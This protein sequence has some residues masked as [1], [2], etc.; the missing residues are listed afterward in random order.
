VHCFGV[1]AADLLGVLRVGF[2]GEI[3]FGFG[4]VFTAERFFGAGADRAKDCDGPAIKAR[5]V[6]SKIA[7]VSAADFMFSLHSWAC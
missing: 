1:W 6:M 4:T 3:G 7:G 5:A 2:S